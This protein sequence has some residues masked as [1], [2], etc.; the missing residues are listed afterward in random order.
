MALLA[1]GYINGILE[2]HKECNKVYSTH[3]ATGALIIK[4]QVLPA[5]HPQT[6]PVVLFVSWTHGQ[7]RTAACQWFKNS[8]LPVK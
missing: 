6:I 7:A 5:F 3:F 8:K 2:H 1:R 4:R